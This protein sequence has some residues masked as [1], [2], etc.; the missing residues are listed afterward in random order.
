MCKRGRAMVDGKMED[1]GQPKKRGVSRPED[2]NSCH[3]LVLLQ[4]LS[5]MPSVV[6]DFDSMPA[7]D[8]RNFPYLFAFMSHLNGLSAAASLALTRMPVKPSTEIAAATKGTK[9]GTFDISSDVVE[10]VISWIRV[11]MN[12]SEEQEVVFC[13]RKHSVYAARCRIYMKLSLS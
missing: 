4:L 7:T 3:I 8:R 9:D 13:L 11:L 6:H 2:D 5:N 12:G 10:Q 1:K